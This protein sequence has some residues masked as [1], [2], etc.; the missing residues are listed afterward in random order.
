MSRGTLAFVV[1]EKEYFSGKQRTFGTDLAVMVAELSAISLHSRRSLGGAK[2]VD[3][4]V[5]GTDRSGVRSVLIVG[6]RGASM[7][8]G[9]GPMA[10]RRILRGLTTL[11]VVVATASCGDRRE[12]PPPTPASPSVPPPTL[13]ISGV[14]PALSPGQTAQMSAE[15]VAADGRVSPCTASWAVDDPRVATVS[16]TGLLTG[17]MTGY[18]R[19]AGTCQGISAAV[20]TKTSAPSPYQWII[21]AHDSALPTEFGVAA[22]LEFLDGPRAGEKIRLGSV[23]TNG[24]P[25]TEWPVRARLNATDYAETE[26]VLAEATGKRRNSTSP[27][28]D[29][30]I[31]CSSSPT[32]PPT[33]T[34][35]R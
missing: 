3:A 34:S 4:G 35:V 2:T 11:C 18:V 17:G 31:P 7:V 6:A 27:L 5:G 26:I 24:T 10:G 29:F 8:L 28:F 14:P 9:S 33:P 19:I 22:T 23:F 32:P 25:G 15:L 21:V 12:P 20:E 30:R 13:R 1:G 16:P